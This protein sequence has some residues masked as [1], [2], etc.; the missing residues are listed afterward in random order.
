[1]PSFFMRSEASY[2]NSAL[3][4]TP[5]SRNIIYKSKTQRVVLRSIHLLISINF[6]ST[7]YIIAP[8]MSRIA[9]Y[10]QQHGDVSGPGD[11]RPSALQ[12][13]KDQGL[14]GAWSGKVVLIT[15]CSPGGLGPEIARA[16]HAT[17]ADL[18][19]TSRDIKK[20]R[21]LPGT[22]YLLENRERL[23]SSTRSRVARQ[24]EGSIEELPRQER[25]VEYPY[26]QCG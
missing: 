24:C 25:E 19:I 18:F 15:G 11:S 16:I 8:S 10:A 4:E 12:I 3:R 1:M 7:P 23:K 26:Q 6:A 2:Y 20:Q 13:V 9:P 17:G 14:Q 21:P 22:F 5:M